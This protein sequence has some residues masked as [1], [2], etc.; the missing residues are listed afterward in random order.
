MK[1][2]YSHGMTSDRIAQ[3]VGLFVLIPLIG[4]VVV[5]YF[6]ATAEHLF[7]RKFHLKASLSKS[8]GLEPGAPVMM[9]GFQIGRV[10]QVELNERGRVDVSLQL[11]ARYQPMVREGAE[12]SVSRSGVVVGQ[13]VIEIGLGD[14]RAP[15]LTDGATIRVSEP[16]DIAE[17]ISEVQPVLNAVKQTLLRVETITQELQSAVQSGGKA[18]EQVAT[19]SQELPEMV[20]SVKRTVASVEQT[21]RTLP[22]VTGSVQ[23]TLKTVDGIAGDVK[24]LTARLPAVLDTTQATA[25]S[26]QGLSESVKTM[27]DDI[28]PIFQSTQAVIDD[29]ATITRGAKRTFPISRFVAN[30]GQAP[31]A[32]KESGTVGLRGDDLSR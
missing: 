19:A 17:L 25:K 26:V 30:A 22:D 15:A 21:V 13:T 28:G 4:L 32:G 18:I 27:T 9:S 11:L 23:K 6:M 3:I 16:R 29:L 14:E 7:E 2:H 5:G 20:Q 8:Y 24:Q 12:A 1:M 10:R 31:A